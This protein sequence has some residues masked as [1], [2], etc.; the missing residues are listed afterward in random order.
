MVPT[1]G[2]E[3]SYI[4]DQELVLGIDINSEAHAYLHQTGWYH[5]IVKDVVA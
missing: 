3:A 1:L 5:E 2:S 4:N